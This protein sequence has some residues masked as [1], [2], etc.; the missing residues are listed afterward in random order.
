MRTRRPTVIL[1]WLALGLALVVPVGSRFHQ[2]WA[3]LPSLGAWCVG[4]TGHPPPTASVD[5]CAYCVWLAQ[6]PWLGASVAWLWLAGVLP[7]V[8]QGTKRLS[9]FGPSPWAIRQGRGHR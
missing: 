2:A 1:A 6:S 5:A 4:H 7:A 8:T 9:R 3:G